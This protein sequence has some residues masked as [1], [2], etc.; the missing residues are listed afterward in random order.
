MSPLSIQIDGNKTVYCPGET[1]RGAI[2]WQYDDRP[3]RIELRLFWFT[4]GPGPDD[5]GIVDTL[6]QDDPSPADTRSF[7]FRVPAG[8]YSYDGKSFHIRWALELLAPDRKDH[9][10]LGLIVSPTTQPI[11]IP[12]R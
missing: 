2:R 1:L 10:R 6:V 4:E 9:T 8:P 11:A 12:F 7:Q 3:G 5:I